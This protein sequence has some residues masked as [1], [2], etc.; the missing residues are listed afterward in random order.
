MSLIFLIGYMGC[1]KTTLAKKLASK[2]KYEWLDT[3]AYIEKQVGLTISEIFSR[4][5]ETYFRSLEQNLINSLDTSKSIVVSTGGG[6]PCFNNVIDVLNEKGTTVYLERSPK[7][8]FQ[9]LEQGKHKRPLLADKSHEE[10]LQFIEENLEKRNPIYRKSK[11]ILDRDYQT[12]DS[13][14][15]ITNYFRHRIS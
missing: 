5:G 13:I 12:V 14:L 9:R 4:Y 6:L 2:L 8:L 3:D 10:L 11:Y 1:G 15:K 7:E